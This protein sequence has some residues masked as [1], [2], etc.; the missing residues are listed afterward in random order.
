MSSTELCTVRTKV[1][2]PSAKS[3]GRTARAKRSNA[4]PT[5]ETCAMNPSAM[6]VLDTAPM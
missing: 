5:S 4:S 1:N 3:V 6:S 2:S